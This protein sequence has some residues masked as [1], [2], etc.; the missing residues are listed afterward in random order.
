PSVRE[1]TLPGLLGEFV[2]KYK[3]RGNCYVSMPPDKVAINFIEL[4]DMPDNEIPK[5]LE[6]E[7]KQRLRV[8]DLNDI[9]FDYVVAGAANRVLLNNRVGV[10]AVSAEKKVIKDYLDIFR[11][12]G[13][14]PLALDAEQL[15]TFAL[16]E[17]MKRD[18][19]DGEVMVSVEL[20][21]GSTYM[22][23]I[24]NGEIMSVRPLRI[25]GNY[26]TGAIKKSLNTTWAEAEKLKKKAG[27]SSGVHVYESHTTTVEETSVMTVISP[28]MEDLVR[29]IEHTFKYFSHQVTRS[30]VVRFDKIIL[31]GGGSV[32]KGFLPFLK[33]KLGV[34]IIVADPAGIFGT[35]SGVGKGEAC[36][37]EMAVACGLAMRGSV[38]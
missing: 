16:I 38:K 9:Y 12:G 23:V 15:S 34:E 20:G 26:I 21:A 2:S 33:E 8:D 29:D 7:M 31:T 13:L 19:V 25:T 36:G 37:P 18:H 22:S 1:Q 4:P 3:L 14:N 17:Y 10:L 27:F 5:A 32:L 28:L 6:W 30:Q 35:A 24:C 11:A